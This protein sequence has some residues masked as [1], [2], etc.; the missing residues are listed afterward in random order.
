MR[1]S[2]EINCAILFASITVAV[3]IRLDCTKGASLPQFTALPNRPALRAHL[4]ITLTRS[5]PPIRLPLPLETFP[6]LLPSTCIYW[7]HLRCPSLKFLSLPLMSPLFPQPASTPLRNIHP[8]A[9]SS[10]PSTPQSLYQSSA[11]SLSIIIRFSLFPPNNPAF[12]WRAT[13]V[14][15]TV[16]EGWGKKTQVLH[17]IVV[18][19]WLQLKISRSI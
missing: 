2:Y 9:L 16:W 4:S 19:K 7:P 15:K 14:L 8:I 18:R 11:M 5:F 6:S 13:V 1:Y 10:V 17:H 12:F 3:V